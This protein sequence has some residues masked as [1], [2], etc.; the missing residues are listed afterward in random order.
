MAKDKQKKKEKSEEE[1]HVDH[2]YS[3]KCVIFLNIFS[4][5]A[6][7]FMCAVGGLLIYRAVDGGDPADAFGLSAD[8]WITT[9]YSV[10]MGLLV[11]ASSGG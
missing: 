2:H 5:V 3:K 6:G 10:I 1:K 8:K 11:L 4:F 7:G 9:I